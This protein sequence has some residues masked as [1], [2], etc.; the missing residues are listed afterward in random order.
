MLRITPV[1]LLIH[2][3]N[4]NDCSRENTLKTAY[5]EKIGCVQRIVKT[6]HEEKVGSVCEVLKTAYENKIG[7]VCRVL[8]TDHEDKIGCVCKAHMENEGCVCKEHV[9]FSDAGKVGASVIFSHSNIS[10]I[11]SFHDS[12]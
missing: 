1:P 8:K 3:N 10:C 9:A 7:S 11:S 12:H 2:V 6:D 5:V 4:R